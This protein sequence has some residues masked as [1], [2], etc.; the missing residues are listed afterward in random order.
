[1]TEASSESSVVRLALALGAAFSGALLLYAITRVIQ[2]L[3]GPDPDPALVLWSEHSGYFWRV[4]IASYAGGMLG[5]FAWVAAGRAPER[6]ARVLA[7]AVIVAPIVL[8]L[9]ALCAP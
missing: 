1:M 6:T 3:L 2:S 4:G 7:G 8:A 5:F 9:Q